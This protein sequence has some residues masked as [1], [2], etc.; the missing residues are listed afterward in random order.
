MYSPRQPFSNV[1]YRLEL[2]VTKACNNEEYGYYANL[3]GVLCWLVQLSRI[4]IAFEISVLSQHMAHPRTGHLIQALHIFKYLNVHKE[5]MLNFN[6]TYLDLP[7]PLDPNHNAKC[8]MQDWT[9]KWFYSD[10]RESIPDN[11]PPPRGK[12]VQINAFVDANHAENKVT[13]RWHIGFIIF[14][15]MAPVYWYSKRQNCVEIS[16]YS[17]EMVALRIISK[18]LC[19]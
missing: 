7:E 15:N 11:A 14:M 19:L 16:T 13:R 10:T 8:K 4:D 3:I 1:N 9:V 17:S 18:K 6:P 2:D 12:S 5:N